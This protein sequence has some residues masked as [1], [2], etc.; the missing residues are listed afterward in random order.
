MCNSVLLKDNISVPISYYS[1][2]Y[3]TYIIRIETSIQRYKDHLIKNEMPSW[4]HY[5]NYNV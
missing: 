3:S 2:A 5:K 4:V 1:V